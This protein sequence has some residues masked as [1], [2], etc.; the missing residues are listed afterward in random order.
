MPRAPSAEIP[1]RLRAPPRNVL[2]DL[3]P[4]LKRCGRHL[5]CEQKLPH[6]RHPTLG[7]YRESRSTF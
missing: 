3:S 4:P 1:G 5:Y 2:F 6:P 7:Q